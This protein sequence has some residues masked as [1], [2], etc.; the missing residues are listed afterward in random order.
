MKK[1]TLSIVA[2]ITAICVNA[3]SG[4][5]FQY[6]MSSDKGMGGTMDMN[7]SEYGHLSEVNMS[8]PQMPGGEMK[9]KSLSNKSNPDVSYIIDDKNKTYREQKQNTAA[10]VTDEKEVTVK[11]L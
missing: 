2:L 11:K 10:P 3:Q 4:A 6:K 5:H 1:L 9:M 7:Y 8:A